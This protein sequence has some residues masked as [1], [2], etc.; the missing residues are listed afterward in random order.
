MKK[1]IL[2]FLCLVIILSGCTNPAPEDSGSIYLFGESHGNKRILEKEL[3]L[4]QK[5]YNSGYRH[6]FVELAY[7]HGE[8]LNL[9]MQSD[10]DKIL[11]ELF[12]D[13]KGT[14][15]CNEYSYNFYKAIKETCPE[16]IFHGTDVGH[17]Y[18]TSGKRYLQYLEEEDLA[19]SEKYKLA[20]KAIEQGEIYYRNDNK[21]YREKTMTE[22]FI[23]EFESLGG[24]SVVGFYGAAHTNPKGMAHGTKDTPCMAKRLFEKYGDSLYAK[25][26]VRFA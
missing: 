24:K 7:Y 10:D 12:E 23:R 26:L 17:Q 25:S 1:A 18:E 2:L 5:F 16:T 4:W 19:D 11:D 14:A 8:F 6:L 9:W 15:G 22:N 3:E 13:W 21:L 20:L